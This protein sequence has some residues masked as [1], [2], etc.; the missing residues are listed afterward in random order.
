MCSRVFSSLELGF[1]PCDLQQTIKDKLARV[2]RLFDQ[3]CAVTC[4]EELI[5]FLNIALLQFKT[6]Y[7]L[8]NPAYINL[9]PVDALIQEPV[10]NALLQHFDIDANEEAFLGDLTEYTAIFSNY[11]Q[12]D[13]GIACCYNLQ[14]D[15]LQ[16]VKIRREIFDQAALPLPQISTLEDQM[17]YVTL[18]NDVDYFQLVQALYSTDKSY[19]VTWENYL[20]VETVAKQ[21]LEGLCALFPG[22]LFAYLVP[23]GSSSAAGNPALLD[24]LRQYWGYSAFRSIQTYDVPRLEHGEKVRMTISQE[25]VIQDLIEQVERCRAGENFRDIF[26]TA[27]TG[28][29]KSLM[30]QLP[31]I[32]LAERYGLLTLVVTP[33]IGLMDDQVSGLEG[34]QY[35]AAR[36]IHSDISPIVKRQIIQEVTDG[37]CHILYLSPESL[38]NRG[39]IEQFFSTRRIGML[40]VD[41]AHIV[42]TWGKQFRPDYWCLGD[43]VQKL[44]RTQARRVDAPSAFI[45]ATFTATAIYGG[46]EDMYHETL[47]SLHMIDP[48]TYLGCVKRDNIDIQISQLVTK[49]DK[50]EYEM[51]KYNALIGLI[52]LALMRGQKLLIYFPTIALIKRFYDYCDSQGLREHIAQYYGQMGPDDKKDNLAAFQS[53]KRKTMLATKAFG[54][55]IDIEDIVTVSHFAPTGNVCDYMQEIGR[56][57]RALGIQGH[58]IYQHMKNDFTHINRL[59][60]LSMIQNY[61]LVE[62]IKKILALYQQKRFEDRDPPSTKKRN[63]M[64]INAEDFAY[65]FDGP[66]SDEHDLMNKVKTAMLLIQKDYENRGFAPFHMRPMPMHGK[67]YFSMLPSTQVRLNQQYPDVATNFYGP[68]NIYEVNLESIWEQ[69]YQGQYSFPRFKFLLYSGSPDI[70]FNREQTLL[71][72]MRVKVF[73]QGGAEQRFHTLLAALRQVAHQ[74]IYQGKY[75]AIQEMIDAVMHIVSLP[76]FRVESM[77][78]VALAAMDVYRREYANRMNSAMYQTRALRNGTVCYQFSAACRDFFSWLEK[79]FQF[80]QQSTQENELYVVNRGMGHNRCREITTILGVLEAFDVL[81][82]ISIGGSNSQIYLYV[83]ETKAMQMVRDNPASYRN[84]LLYTIHQRHIASV[85]MMTYL[86]QSNFSSAEIWEHLENYFL[87]MVPEALNLAAV[88]QEMSDIP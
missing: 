39:D 55:G 13:A 56:A 17:Q 88:P 20:S 68:Q 85:R 44:R 16:H 35:K 4:F 81:H 66:L 80:V 69:S 62:V 38:L 29:G 7:I 14:P 40:V 52:R 37:K 33:L 86:F 65:I 30:F 43:H 78:H 34:I 32:Y 24:L 72:A 22:R 54:M 41:E 2:G 71:P 64:L 49:Q 63:E 79:G 76:H 25:K 83:T 73:F 50:V 57:A 12:T 61:Q 28:S 47:N 70:A 42:T 53:G 59:H 84:K 45:I 75:F 6:I 18:C 77:V 21:R 1:E 67:G 26:V 5:C 11:V 48:I 15:Q 74:S 3:H 10:S 27:S 36:A 51:D 60:G 23:A 58:A 82:F 9:Y 31:A 8:E 19:A 46:P 87:G